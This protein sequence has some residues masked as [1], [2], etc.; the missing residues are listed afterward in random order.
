MLTLPDVTPQAGI[1]VSDPVMPSAV[2]T[3]KS[4]TYQCVS[5]YVDGRSLRIEHSYLTGVTTTPHLGISR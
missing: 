4:C 2:N 5:A 3:T 1:F